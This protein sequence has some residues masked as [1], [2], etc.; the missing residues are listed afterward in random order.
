M[1][2]ALPMNGATSMLNELSEEEKL[3]AFV[4]LSEELMGDDADEDEDPELW[5]AATR[6]VKKHVPK[7][8]INW[9]KRKMCGKARSMIAQHCKKDDEEDAELWG[10]ATRW[11]ARKVKAVGAMPH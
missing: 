9:M 7:P 2:T 10:K 1:G 5:G 6:F 4:Q 3:D 11:A 8:A